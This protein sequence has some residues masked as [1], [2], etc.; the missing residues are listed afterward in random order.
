[1][2][3]DTPRPIVIE[4]LPEADFRIAVGYLDDARREC[5]L[6]LVAQGQGRATDPVLAS[7]A[8]RLVPAI[9]AVGDAFLA[10]EATSDGAGS[11]RLRGAMDLEQAAA[12][13]ELQVQLVQL[14]TLVRRGDLLLDSEPA[15]AALITW[16]CE[17]VADQLAGRAPRPYVAAGARPSGS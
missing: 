12:V 11:L 10:A 15:V 1:M 7:V 16:L 8:S 5:Q 6:V 13:A 3:T 2:S 9:E 17:E 4:D 14:R